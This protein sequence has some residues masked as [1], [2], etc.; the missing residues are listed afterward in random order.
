MKNGHRVL[1]AYCVQCTR[2]CG[3][4][5]PQAVV[6]GQAAREVTLYGLCESVMPEYHTLYPQ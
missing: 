1:R 3:L 5:V 6:N 4:R 2:S